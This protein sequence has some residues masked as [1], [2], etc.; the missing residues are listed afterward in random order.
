MGR[1]DNDKESSD[2]GDNID[3]SGVEMGLVA[4]RRGQQKN[5]HSVDK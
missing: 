5:E 3:D 2:H 1:L 4:R